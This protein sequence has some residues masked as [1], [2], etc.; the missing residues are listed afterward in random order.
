MTTYAMSPKPG[1]DP[2]L[3]GESKGDDVAGKAGHVLP[4]VES[5]FR[6][7]PGIPEGMV[8][9]ELGLPARRS[10]LGGGW[11]GLAQLVWQEIEIEIPN[12]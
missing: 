7:L 6:Q 3:L 12:V 5:Q 9:A 2:F 4:V 11:L 8:W 1:G 10:I